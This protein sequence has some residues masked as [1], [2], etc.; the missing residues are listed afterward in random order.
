MLIGMVSIILLVGVWFLYS[1]MKREIQLTQIKSEFISNVSH[2]IR[3][4]LALI[5]MYIETLDMGRVKTQ[6]R[7]LNITRLLV[8]KPA[9]GCH[10]KQNPQFLENGKRQAP[11]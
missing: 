6:K 3:T 11:V 10:G 4:P 9:A 2:E 5:S 7:W 8:K 1:S